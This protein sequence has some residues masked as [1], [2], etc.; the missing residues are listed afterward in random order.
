MA[1]TVVY[2]PSQIADPPIARLLF[3]DTRFGMDL[4]DC[5]LVHGVHLAHLGVRQ[6]DEC[7]MGRHGRSAQ[8]LLA[9]CI[10]DGPQARYYV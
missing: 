1:R 4:G 8:G 5:S 2:Q 3:A 6:I 10:E 9:G 7:R